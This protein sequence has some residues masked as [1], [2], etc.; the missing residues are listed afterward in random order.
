MRLPLRKKRVKVKRSVWWKPPATRLSPKE[1]YGMKQQCH[2]WPQPVFCGTLISW[3]R[4]I[5]RE[6]ISPSAREREIWDGYGNNYN[7]AVSTI[8]MPSRVCWRIN[9]NKDGLKNAWQRNT[10]ARNWEREDC[11]YRENSWCQGAGETRS[12]HDL[13]LIRQAV[14][15]NSLLF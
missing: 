8:M 4:D 7:Y 14:V 13:K 12:L 6:A 10:R 5:N 11:P 9:S 2:Q 1:D 3:A 15:P